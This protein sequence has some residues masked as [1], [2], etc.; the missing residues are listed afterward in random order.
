MPIQEADELGTKILDVRVERQPHTDLAMFPIPT[1]T[2]A[3]TPTPSPTPLPN[4]APLQRPVLIGLSYNGGTP[5]V[6]GTNLI[7]GTKY[8]I[9]AQAD[10]HTQSI[11]FATKSGNA[12]V[13][14]PPFFSLYI[15]RG[16][17]AG[18]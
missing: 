4:A 13:S 11:V 9:T 1:P 16:E 2:P 3:P 8:T 5:F 15:I 14:L 12:I 7:A 17:S 10:S 18:F 6:D